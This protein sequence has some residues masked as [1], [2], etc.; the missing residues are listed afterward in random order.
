[1]FQRLSIV[2]VMAL[3]LSSATAG[4]QS[5]QLEL[6]IG[7]QV[8]LKAPSVSAKRIQGIL[9]AMDPDT[10]T[11]VGRNKGGTVQV[12]RSAIA[13]LEVAKGKKSRAAG[14]AAVGGAIGVLAGVLASNPPSSAESFSISPGAVLVCGAVGAAVGALA[15]SLRE[16]DRWVTVSAGNLKVTVA[17]V[18]HGGAFIGVRVSF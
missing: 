16:T 17:P 2:S 1:M 14:G 18:E 6:T 7:D 3:V 5:E 15:G 11:V 12:A 8:R 10:V 9:V 13:S 4:A